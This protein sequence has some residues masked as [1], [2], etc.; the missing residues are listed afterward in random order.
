V[1]PPLLLLSGLLLWGPPALRV[2]GRDR[3]AALEQPLQLDA[4]A[5]LQVGSWVVAAVVAFLLLLQHV[6]RRTDYL[7]GVLAD[8]TLRWYL[9]FGCLAM[10]TCLYSV[11][12]LYTSFFAL[13]LLVAPFVLT[14]LVWHSAR[15]SRGLVLRLFFAVYA[16]QAVAVLVLYMTA[17]HVVT[18]PEDE[19]RLTGGMFVDYGTSAFFVGIFLITQVLYAR[20]RTVRLLALLGYAGTWVMLALSQT[21]STMAVALIAA[22]VMA[23]ASRRVRTWSG[24]LAAAAVL[25]LGVV[26][27]ATLLALGSVL[28]RGGDGLSTLSGRTVVFSY[29][30]D[31]WQESPWIGYGYAAGT[32]EQLVDFP[33]RSGLGIGSGHDL[34]STALVDV[35]VI[36]LTLMVL[37]VGSVWVALFRQFRRTTSGSSERLHLHQLLCLLIYVT[38]VGIVNPGIATYS[39]AFL[40][41]VVGL[42]S[43]KLPSA[44]SAGRTRQGLP[45]RESGGL[46]PVPR[47]ELPSKR[48]S[49]ASSAPSG[50]SRG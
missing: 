27:P 1:G 8:P 10:T 31:R 4:A 28:T 49:R 17:R 6:A 13:K 7:P 5:A 40:V 46:A 9:S 19:V 47:P 11:A 36:G 3:E 2:P 21:R 26:L 41:V 25:A 44:A 16:A 38:L 14:L 42:W 18:P 29:L 20:D 37:L 50:G 48:C 15:R 39:P 33:Q 23:M 30:V 24:L 35:G 12:T 34:L 32:R 43:M 22:T 45:M